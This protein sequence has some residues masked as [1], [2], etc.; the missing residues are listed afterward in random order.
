M[1][2]ALKDLHAQGIIHRDIKPENVLVDKEL[3]NAL[4]IIDFG[5]SFTFNQV[6]NEVQVTT[7]EYLP[8]EI[9]DFVEFRMMNIVGYNDS[10]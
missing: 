2:R 8:P 5:T 1:V 6:N 10:I 4:K 3:G 9:L 7:P